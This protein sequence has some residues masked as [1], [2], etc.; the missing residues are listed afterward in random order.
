MKRPNA[1][2]VKIQILFICT[3]FTITIIV[4]RK[5]LKICH[6]PYAKDFMLHKKDIKAWYNDFNPHP[7][8]FQLQKLRRIRRI[9]Y[10]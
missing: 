10:Q 3:S 8:N 7:Y 5:T 1:E 4:L 9:R 2:V 6:R